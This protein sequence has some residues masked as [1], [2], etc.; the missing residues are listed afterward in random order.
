MLRGK[1]VAKSWFSSSQLHHVPKFFKDVTVVP[2]IDP[3]G[4]HE[5]FTIKLDKRTLSTADGHRYFLPSELL[6][7]IVCMEFYSQKDYI[8]STSMPMVDLDHQF[9]FTKS[10]VDFVHSPLLQQTAIARLC[11]F[12]KGDTAW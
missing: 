1:L 8:V 11:R 2:F 3:T 4:L 9:G 5:G 10:A 6:A 12:I 7:H